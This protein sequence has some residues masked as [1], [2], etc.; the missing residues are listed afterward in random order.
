MNYEI[1]IFHY[2]D[3]YKKEWKRIGFVMLIVLFVTI[4]VGI[5]QPTAYRSTAIILSP[6]AGGQTGGVGQYLSFL[7][8]GAGSGSDDVVFSM[9]KSARMRR[10]IN[11]YFNLKENPKF[12]WILDTYIVTGGFAVEVKGPDPEMTEKIANFAITNLDKIN[13]ELQVTAQRPMAKVLDPAVKGAPMSKNIFKRA[14]AVTL[15]VFMVYFLF[16]FFREYLAQL[17]S[18]RKI[19]SI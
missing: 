5:L 7:N 15:I 8:I 13:A 2:V 1:N 6:K 3:I 11:E 10:D 18:T 12:W 16:I 17:K 4:F 14:I 9:L 19:N